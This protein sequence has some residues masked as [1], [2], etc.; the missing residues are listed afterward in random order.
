MATTTVSEFANLH[1]SLFKPLGAAATAGILALIGFAISVKAPS[2]TPLAALATA[3]ILGTA[4]WMLLTERYEWSLTVLMLYIGLADGYI[5]LRTG[6][7]NA[8]L[9]RDLLLYSIAAGAVLRL[10]VRHEKV[11][12]PP[13]AMWVAVWVAIVVVQIANPSNGTLFHSIAS[14]RQHIEWIPLF[15]FGYLVIRT[16]N[17]LRWFLLLLVTVA[18]IN[19]VVG[20]VQFNMTPEQLSGWGPGYEEAINGT[21]TISSRTYIDSTGTART[22]P[23]G[24]GGDF[25]FAGIVGMLAVPAAFG[26]LSLARRPSLRMATVPLAA[27][28]VIAIATSNARVDVV[29]SVI[30]GLAYLCL[31]VTSRA[32]LRTVL[33]V[34]VALAVSYGTVSLLSSDTGPRS[35]ERYE[36]IASPSEAISTTIDY[37]KGTLSLIPKYI[38]DFPLGAGIGSNGPAAN[39]AGG[40]TEHAHLNAESEPNFLLIEL[41]VP[42]LV[43]FYGFTLALFG[44]AVTRIRRITDRELRILLTAVA[45][46]L[47]A[48]A[49]TGIVGITT[50]ATPAA[51][52][53]WFAAG[54]MAY[55]LRGAGRQA[56]SSSHPTQTH[57]SA[58]ARSA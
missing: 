33:A 26:L 53:L 45:A 50:A 54:V 3:G 57:E 47:F 41:G 46:P 38:Q 43:L 23:F 58:F 52:Y 36:S 49:A 15:F 48:L 31:T 27:G 28:V 56:V 19:G 35:F 29:G 8:T 25:G 6:S 44:L 16:K 20:L 11:S 32:G 9:V 55:W 4:A 40:G 42:G 39:L 12:F 7:S 22:R 1:R 5:K 14:T 21:D 2:A 34:S 30:A 10:A 51:P 18:A 17:R 13:L 37:R 24:L